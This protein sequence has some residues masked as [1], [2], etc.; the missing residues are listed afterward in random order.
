MPAALL[1]APE[2]FSRGRLS[3]RPWTA[4]SAW[5]QRL[6]LQVGVVNQHKRQE[7]RLADRAGRL[8]DV[9]VDRGEHRLRV[10]VGFGR[11]PVSV[12]A[13]AGIPDEAVVDLERV[14]P[15]EEVEGSGWRRSRQ[16]AKRRS[17]EHTSE[18]QSLM[19]ISYAVFCLKK[20]KKR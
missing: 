9:R 14:L 6:G 19:R 1:G 12:E 8:I 13:R 11:A 7:A 3:F 17:E 18:L 15:A 10:G 2:G 20:K 4:T 16:R 5:R